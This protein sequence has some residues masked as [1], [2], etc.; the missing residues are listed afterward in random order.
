MRAD[1]LT[2]VRPLL[3]KSWE[4]N[5]FTYTHQSVFGG[6]ERYAAGGGVWCIPCMC[7]DRINLILGTFVCCE[8]G[9]DPDAEFTWRK[10]RVTCDGS[11]CRAVH[12]QGCFSRLFSMGGARRVV[13]HEAPSLSDQAAG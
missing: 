4:E 8:K 6:G 7:S 5:G 10:Q 9:R 11:G 2:G 12:M 13:S 3:V 1:R